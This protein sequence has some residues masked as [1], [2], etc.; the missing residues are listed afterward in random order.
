[1]N[2]TVVGTGADTIAK[3]RKGLRMKKDELGQFAKTPTGAATVIGGGALTGKGIEK[4]VDPRKLKA[5][6]VKGGKTGFRSAK[7]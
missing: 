3:A 7:S 6:A 1:M 4:N 2:P 5:P